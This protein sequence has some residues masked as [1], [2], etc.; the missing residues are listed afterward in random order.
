MFGAARTLS[1]AIDNTATLERPSTITRSITSGVTLTDAYAHDIGTWLAILS[2]IPHDTL[3]EWVGS[4]SYV[5]DFPALRVAGE[6]AIPPYAAA[7]EGTVPALASIG[8]VTIPPY[9]ATSESV[10]PQLTA[11]AESAIPD[12][13]E[14]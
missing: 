4:L 3:I 10:I 14:A 1:S 12:L 9:A 11:A 7:A 5:G 2:E 8:G 13:T 6:D